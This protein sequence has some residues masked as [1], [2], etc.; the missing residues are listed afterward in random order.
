MKD[1]LS[2]IQPVNTTDTNTFYIVI[3][4]FNNLALAQK[5]YSVLTNYGNKLVLT[6]KDSV[7]YKLKMPFQKPLSDTLRVKDSIGI[8]FQART[9]VELP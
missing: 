7:T 3:K 4:E 8:F 1:S 5:R 6:T 9:Y 2:A